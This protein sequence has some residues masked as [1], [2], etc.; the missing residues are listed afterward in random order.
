MKPI[1]IRSILETVNPLRFH[2]ISGEN[3]SG[4]FTKDEQTGR[5]IS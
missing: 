1:E 3:Y 4:T 2:L 5:L